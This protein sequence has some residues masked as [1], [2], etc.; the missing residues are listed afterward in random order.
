MPVGALLIPDFSFVLLFAM[1]PDHALLEG[2]RL[3]KYWQAACSANAPIW[4]R[5]VLN[6]R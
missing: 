5:R 2:C 1:Q 3:R 4:S 6:A